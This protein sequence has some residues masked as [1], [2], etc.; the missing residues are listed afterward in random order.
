MTID[1]S[2]RVA[3]LHANSARVGVAGRRRA[4][5]PDDVAPAP[6]PDRPLR[7][8][9]ALV[10]LARYGLPSLTRDMLEDYVVGCESC[11]FVRVLAVD[12]VV[13]LLG[14]AQATGR[15]TVTL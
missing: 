13:A 14:E 5:A 6:T 9:D 7:G 1:G 12:D 15:R 2:E 10:W 11:A 8:A 4:T 3:E